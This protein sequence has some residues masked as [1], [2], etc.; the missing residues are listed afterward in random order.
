[1]KY[2]SAMLQ[3]GYEIHDLPF[4]YPFELSKGLK[5]HQP[6]LLVSLG[7]RNL[8]G[9]GETT[10][11]RYYNTSVQTMAE[12]LE[13]H[14]KVIESYSINSPERFWHFLH[15]LFPGNNFL[16]SALDIAGWD[17]W[18]H[19]SRKPVRQLMRLS[20]GNNP[21]TDYTIGFNAPE[22][23][24]QRVAEK[25]F[26]AY[27]LK[28][29]GK[30]DL[31]ALEALRSATDGAI[32]IDANEGWTL[33][34]AKAILPHLEKCNVQLIEQPFNR[35]DLNSLETLRSMTSIP[36]IADEACK[37]EKDL[38]SCLE[39]YDGINIKLSKCGG[40]TPALRMIGIIKRSGKKVMLGG[41]CE[42]TVGA[43]ALAQLLPLADY[44]DIDGPLLLRENIGRGLTYDHGAIML[45]PGPGLGVTF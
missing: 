20:P 37:D 38:D 15:H 43:T 4:E 6:L 25:Q 1:M 30:D 27:K 9:Y 2:K 42:S 10:E 5:T 34:E 19:M 12:Q 31:K 28:V 33:E 39:R 8:K 26:P 36:V 13:Q 41:M 7:F 24:R 16:I 22:A 32:R 29:G 17:L 40:L 44:A 23:I 45:P 11:I 35:V 3:L 14:R 18:G 21:P